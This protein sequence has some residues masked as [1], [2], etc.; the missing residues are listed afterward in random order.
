MKVGL[1]A[2]NDCKNV[3]RSVSGPRCV[4]VLNH[5]QIAMGMRKSVFFQFYDANPHRQDCW[6]GPLLRAVERQVFHEA[7]RQYAADHLVQR[8]VL[9]ACL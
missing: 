7:L 2:C 8:Y 1:R 5:F 9:S 3:T 6:S 4:R